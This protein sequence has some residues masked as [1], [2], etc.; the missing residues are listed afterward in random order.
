M[1]V[2]LRQLRS[3]ICGIK[4]QWLTGGK[5]E[6][7]ERRMNMATVQLQGRSRFSNTFT[8]RKK[9]REPLNGFLMKLFV[10]IEQSHSKA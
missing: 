4:R 1:W 10:L 6:Y 7:F 5:S 8:T 9:P 2:T 3:L